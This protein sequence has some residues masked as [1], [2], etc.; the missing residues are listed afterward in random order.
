MRILIA[1]LF[2]AKAAVARPIPSRD[3]FNAA[4]LHAPEITI[5]GA[6]ER[7]SAQN[8]RRAAAAM[9]PRVDSTA[10]LTSWADS[11]PAFPVGIL[12]PGREAGVELRAEQTLFQGGT[13]KARYGEA[14]ELRE[15]ASRRASAVREEILHR[16]AALAFDFLE[17]KEALE[18]AA[19]ELTRRQAHW[20]GAQKRFLAGVLSEA[21]LRRTEAEAKRAVAE[22]IEAR[23]ALAEARNRL[24]SLTGLALADGLEVPAA[25]PEPEDDRRVLE[26]KARRNNPETLLAMKKLEAS[27]HA[28]SAAD[29]LWV[30]AVVAG[31][32]QRGSIQTPETLHH[33]RRE[34]YGYLHAR[35]NLFGGGDTLASSRGAREEA[36]AAEG[37][38][39][40][41]ADAAALNASLAL[42]AARTAK[43]VLEADE[44]RVLAA[45]TAY[46][47]S[48]KRHEAGLDPYL[49]LLDAAAALRAAEAEKTKA[50]Y[51]GQR[52]LLDL[53]RAL[54]TVEEALLKGA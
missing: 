23:R 54:G 31:A 39:R 26:E 38:L 44:A 10:G 43:I 6:E 48:L 47:R 28:R 34:A 37:R 24:E 51:A 5:S 12:R 16:A 18:H 2:A 50:R 13:L 19:A 1:V 17:R 22:E 40:K 53:H 32:A 46:Q 41:A 52:A 14:A 15:A 9:L 3:L 36:A 29:G 11:R 27:R 35:W 21:D 25:I 30:P 7:S 45:E 49:N 8:V 42:D 4:I 20:D 33:V